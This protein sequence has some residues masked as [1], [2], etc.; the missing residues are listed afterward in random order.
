M[1]LPP[2]VWAAALWPARELKVQRPLWQKSDRSTGQGSLTIGACMLSR[3]M[4]L[5]VFACF[6]LSLWGCSSSVAPG[7]VSQI[8]DRTSGLLANQPQV[9]QPLIYVS[10]TSD[11][12][13]TAYA[14]DDAGDAAPK[15]RIAGPDTLLTLFQGIAFDT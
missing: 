2:A 5:A 9:R 7:S 13:I 10:N 15:I 8:P 6:C 11:T 12:S 14:V 1:R 4:V 3:V